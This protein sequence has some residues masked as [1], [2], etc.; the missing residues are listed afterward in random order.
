MVSSVFAVVRLLELPW[1]MVGTCM[2][3]EAV[4]EV[5]SQPLVG[6]VVT[7]GGLEVNDM[8]TA[9]EGVKLEE[10]SDVEG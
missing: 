10:P 9:L 7:C 8:G 3:T 2:T 4:A 1:E 5:V 6:S